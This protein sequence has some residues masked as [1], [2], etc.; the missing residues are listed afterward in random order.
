[1]KLL[2]GKSLQ[3]SVLLLSACPS[4]NVIAV[5]TATDL[6]LLRSTSLSLIVTLPLP[7]LKQY[8]AG[9]GGAPAAA[10]LAVGSLSACWSIEGRIFVLSLPDG[11]VLL[12]AVDEGH[13]VRRLVPRGSSCFTA[14]TSS[15]EQVKDANEEA[16]TADG[17]GDPE[18]TST[19]SSS[20]PLLKPGFS[21]YAVR[22]PTPISTQPGV[23]L[24]AMSW[25]ASFL[26]PSSPHQYGSPSTSLSD[27]CSALPWMQLTQEVEPSAG[28]SSSPL[29][30]AA[31][32]A[33]R[34]GP[35][36][37]C[38][39]DT[40]G[41]LVVLL[42]GIRE[43]FHQHFLVPSGAAQQWSDLR[44][45]HLCIVRTPL[46]ASPRVQ[47]EDW[48][49]FADV[50]TFEALL[51]AAAASGSSG[52]EEGNDEA[53][54]EGPQHGASLGAGAGGEQHS[55]CLVAIMNAQQGGRASQC[56]IQLPIGSSLQRVL[57]PSTAV[58]CCADECHRLAS[59]CFESVVTPYLHAHHQL[60]AT[61]GLPAA[62][63][64]LKAQLLNAHGN[65]GISGEAGSGSC[66]AAV[67]NYVCHE[68]F[69][70]TSSP[71]S[72]ATPQTFG[73]LEGD[74]AGSKSKERGKHL[75]RVQEEYH[76]AC[77]ALLHMC[78]HVCEPCY[79][80][81]L[82]LLKRL[83]QD[84]GIRCW[85]DQERPLP[86]SSTLQCMMA[87]LR[88]RCSLYSRRAQEESLA[89]SEVIQWVLAMGSNHPL[90]IRH[91]LQVAAAA[92]EANSRNPPS[93]EEEKPP[94]PQV[95]CQ[96]L[97]VT[98][99]PAVLAWLRR[100]EDAMATAAA[101]SC[102]N[103]HSWGVTW[104]ADANQLLSTVAATSNETAG[105]AGWLPRGSLESTLSAKL[106]QRCG[107]PKVA[108]AKGYY[109]ALPSSTA[110]WEEEPSSSGVFT[111]MQG[112]AG[113]SIDIQQW[114]FRSSSV[115]E[116]LSNEE[117]ADRTSSGWHPLTST[118]TLPLAL[119]SNPTLQPYLSTAVVGG[120]C[121]FPSSAS[122]VV[123]LLVAEV[124]GATVLLA[125]VG[126]D[127]EIELM[128]NPALE[129]DVN[130]EV[131]DVGEEEEEVPAVLQ[132]R[133]DSTPAAS[134][135]SSPLLLS[136]SQQKEFAVFA[137]GSKLVVIDLYV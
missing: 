50:R 81:A 82:T 51:K 28:I 20:S 64:L 1:M 67:T 129:E 7:Q 83:P 131:E 86:S 68:L 57:H 38:L 61:F 31:S 46:P 70:I 16:A 22:H 88:L 15:R 87:A 92:A 101:A 6:R 21:F 79:R 60:L 127:G 26:L 27:V 123:V 124:A 78:E 104:E 54:P 59:T 90:V 114:A 41:N 44:G 74:D 58:L 120:V 55:I 73:G 11:E 136:I 128:P 32:S 96:P 2:H 99:E 72:F 112:G 3:E 10:S 107:S 103:E 111:S 132:V 130:G 19:S 23:P 113:S 25:E 122:Y 84:D 4:M 69:G 137:M 45:K 34:R 105:E 100:Q 42:G 76:R 47:L 49:P 17:S 135:A 95:T 52:N 125:R 109:L 116:P 134:A 56:L 94:L 106:D 63:S 65:G 30:D 8:A 35:S 24:L 117:E 33:S 5:V 71:T 85:D 43:V 36:L 39:L 108:L 37:L 119:G 53:E 110:C 80:V 118:D 89:V 126:E 40:V 102:Q 18:N 29:L 98:R 14:T 115:G 97:S 48:K 91:T 121:S 9:S 75:V 12:L 62:A 13:V 133:L 66:A 77:E 93:N